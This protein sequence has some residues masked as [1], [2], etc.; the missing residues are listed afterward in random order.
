MQQADVCG[1]LY[2]V[3]MQPD[4]QLEAGMGGFARHCML[5]W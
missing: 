3:I 4:K 5:G 1:A 2:K